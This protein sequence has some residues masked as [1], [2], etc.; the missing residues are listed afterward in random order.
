MSNNQSNPSIKLEPSI[1]DQ[2]LAKSVRATLER[3]STLAQPTVAVT[4]LEPISENKEVIR[5]GKREPQPVA[6]HTTAQSSAA[7]SAQINEA[8]IVSTRT[9]QL[10]TESLSEDVKANHFGLYRGYVESF[11]KVSVAVDS[12]PKDDA[13]NPNN[14]QFRRLK[15]DEQFNLNAVKLH[16]LYF[17]NVGDKRSEIRRDSTVFMRLERDWGSFENWQLDFR[18]CGMAAKEGWAVCYYEPFKQKYIN[19]FVESHSEGIPVTGIPVLVVDTW[20]HAWFKD[21]LGEKLTYLNAMLKEVNWDVVEARMACA[22]ASNI[23]QLYMI[24]PSYPA[25]LPQ[26]SGVI[27]PSS[28]PVVAAE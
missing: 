6:V 20:H 19:C 23:H 22:E 14:S 4:S 11:N 27:I 12:V 17:G 25:D 24:Q 9:F 10:G 28:L 13:N 1:L 15:Q 7:T 8:T 26:R 21:Y 2:L 5:F 16:E 18:A 3:V